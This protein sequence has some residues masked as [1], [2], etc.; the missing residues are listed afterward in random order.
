MTA[1]YHITHV[2]NLPAIVAVGALWSDGRL[3]AAGMA[4]KN[5]AHGNIKLRRAQTPVTLPPHG[6]VAD[7]VPLYFCP[8][9]PMLYALKGG[10]VERAAGTQDEIVHLVLDAEALTAAGLACLHTDGNAASQPLRFFEG[11]SGLTSLRWDVIRS[12]SW[13]DTAD[14]NDRKRSKSAEFL[15]HGAVPWAQVQSIGVMTEDT[16]AR[17]AAAIASAAHRPPVTL[18]PDWYYR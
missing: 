11:V 10:K 18:Q 1:I 2:D 7:Y 6:V 4:P 15:V 9:S 3:S 14:D 5:I 13:K 17:A 8:R 12:W 16:R